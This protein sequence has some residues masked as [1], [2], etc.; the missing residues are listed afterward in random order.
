M[1]INNVLRPADKTLHAC[2]EAVMSGDVGTGSLLQCPVPVLA[3][4]HFVSKTPP[5]LNFLSPY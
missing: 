1:N 4:P 2:L 3:T 5:T